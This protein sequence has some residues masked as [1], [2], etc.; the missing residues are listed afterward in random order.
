MKRIIICE[1]HYDRIF[2]EN[3]LSK[4]NIDKDKI[5]F[6]DQETKDNLKELKHAES[7]ILK[8]FIQHTSPYEILSKSEAG[9]EKIIR[10]FS[11]FMVFIFENIE[12][13]SLIVDL[14]GSNLDLFIEKIRSRIKSKKAVGLD[15]KYE[16]TKENQYII[17]SEASVIVKSKKKILDELGRFSIFAFKKSLDRE[18]GINKNDDKDTRKNKIIKLLGNEEI[19]HPFC[20]IKI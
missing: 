1:G 3:L 15:I 17:A 10:V 4:L 19:F 13:T 2:I 8:S 20:S 12:K 7:I 16:I 14:D 11:D 5:K 9:K 6:F 18:A